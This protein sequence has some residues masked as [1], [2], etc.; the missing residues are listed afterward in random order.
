MRLTPP[1]T[2]QGT[3]CTPG[4]QLSR[5]ESQRL[6]CPRCTLSIG[7]L[8]LLSLE[9]AVRVRETRT[10]DCG[11]EPQAKPGELLAV[12][13]CDSG[14]LRR[15]QRRWGGGGDGSSWRAIRRLLA[16][17]SH[18]RSLVKMQVPW[19]FGRWGG[20]SP[21]TCVGT[22]V[23][24]PP[25]K[26]G[27]CS[28]YPSPRPRLGSDT[29]HCPGLQGTGVRGPQACSLLWRDPAWR[30]QSHSL[31]VGM[32]VTGFALQKRTGV[33]AVAGSAGGLAPSWSQRG[34]S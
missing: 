6:R 12:P 3:G 4:S 5:K 24:P 14:P 33:H 1:R 15:G 2:L 31:S 29:V 8:S 34:Q 10:T 20:R 9:A 18:N 11:P 28:S 16:V 17:R 25:G 23:M 32:R 21:G 22:W 27:L 30:L 7:H 19:C 13:W 26:L